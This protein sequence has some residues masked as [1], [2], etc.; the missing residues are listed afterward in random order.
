MLCSVLDR[1]VLAC[2]IELLEAYAEIASASE[3]HFLSR[4]PTM[5]AAVLTKEPQRGV[6]GSACACDPGWSC[7]IRLRHGIHPSFVDNR[8]GLPKRQAARCGNSKILGNLAHLNIHRDSDGFDATNR[9]ST[10]IDHHPDPH[11]PDLRP[12]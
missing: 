9:R 6:K 11:R 2:R 10:R 1:T 7:E 12:A 4:F 5:P 3:S 8:F